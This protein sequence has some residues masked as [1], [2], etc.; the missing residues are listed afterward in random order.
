MFY[1][2][3]S[4][5]PKEDVLPCLMIMIIPIPTYMQN[6]FPTW[7]KCFVFFP[8]ILADRVSY[9]KSK[10]TRGFALDAFWSLFWLQILNFSQKQINGQDVNHQV[11]VSFVKKHDPLWWKSAGVESAEQGVWRA[12][13]EIAAGLTGQCPQGKAFIRLRQIRGLAASYAPSGWG[14]RGGEENWT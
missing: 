7:T 11:W 14:G 10:A 1:N 3:L 8:Y 6:L 12:V 2:L 4:A 13:G 9:S 5:P